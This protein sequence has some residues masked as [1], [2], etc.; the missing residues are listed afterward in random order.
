VVGAWFTKQHT[1]PGRVYLLL[2]HLMEWKARNHHKPI[3][4]MSAELDKLQPAQDDIGWY[5]MMFGNIS[6]L[7]HE[8]KE[9]YYHDLGKVYS[10]L[11]WMSMLIRSINCDK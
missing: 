11:H 8:I 9:H 1:H 7:W 4:N 5:A 10:N 2:G 6:L 3:S